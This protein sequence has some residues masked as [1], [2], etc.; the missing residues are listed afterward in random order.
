MKHCR[1]EL[2]L[3]I[4]FAGFGAVDLQKIEHICNHVPSVSLPEDNNLGLITLS[5]LCYAMSLLCCPTLF[6]H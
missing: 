1:S 4:Y 6:P 3:K 5:E 2:G